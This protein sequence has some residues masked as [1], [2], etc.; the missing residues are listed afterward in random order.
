MARSPQRVSQQRQSLTS[1]ILRTE[2][3]TSDGILCS[4]VE[5]TSSPRFGGQRDNDVALGQLCFFSD[6]LDGIGGAI[7][8]RILSLKLP[9]YHFARLVT[10]DDVE[11]SPQPRG[12]RTIRVFRS[13]QVGLTDISN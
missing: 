1:K 11:P 4:R 13:S 8:R 12:R 9:R 10:L 6:G 7:E 2:V 5:Q 3:Q